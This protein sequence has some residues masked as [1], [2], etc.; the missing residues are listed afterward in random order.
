MVKV[1]AFFPLKIR[2]NLTPSSLK[3]FTNSCISETQDPGL[4]MM[5]SEYS[6]PPQSVLFVSTSI[7]I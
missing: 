2:E 1:N 4:E 5:S 6:H 7:G 3:K